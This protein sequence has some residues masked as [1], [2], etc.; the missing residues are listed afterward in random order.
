MKLSL[1][2][3]HIL[4]AAASE[5]Y[6]ASRRGPEADDRGTGTSGLCI[7]Q[8]SGFL[9]VSVS[10]VKFLDNLFSKYEPNF[11]RKVRTKIDLT[12][13]DHINGLINTKIQ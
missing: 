10:A 4:L 13:M 6:V 3:V 9:C 2:L 7:I 12:L 11:I 5:G 8:G 1:F